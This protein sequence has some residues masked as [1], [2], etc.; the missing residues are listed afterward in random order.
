MM[1]NERFLI[2]PERE[3]GLSSFDPDRQTRSKLAMN[4]CYEVNISFDGRLMA[5]LGDKCLR[6]FDMST[7]EEVGN[8]T[9]K[10]RAKYL[11]MTEDHI[12]IKY[13]EDGDEWSVLSLKETVF[14]KMRMEMALLGISQEEYN[15]RQASS[16]HKAIKAY[17]DKR[18]KAAQIKAA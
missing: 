2:I 8:I 6:L 15:A 13:F 10:E 4:L 16:M 5:C 3:E 9:L 1:E 17:L 18:V 14:S 11:R 12:F 7:L